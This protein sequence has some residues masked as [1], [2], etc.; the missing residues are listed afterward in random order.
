MILTLKTDFL[1]DLSDKL[2]EKG[3]TLKDNEIFIAFIF[4]N[5]TEQAVNIAVENVLVNGIPVGRDMAIFKIRPSGS[6]MVRLS[7]L[8]VNSLFLGGI[9][10]AGVFPAI[11]PRTD[12]EPE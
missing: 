11:E 1:N 8:G 2:N 5:D 10:A 7:D 9:E 3:I 4:K 6:V 12:S